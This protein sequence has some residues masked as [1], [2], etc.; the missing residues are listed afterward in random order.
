M[1]AKPSASV[2][3]PVEMERPV[4][5]HFIINTPTEILNALSGHTT[6]RIKRGSNRRERHSMSAFWGKADIARRH[7]RDVN[8]ST[9]PL[10]ASKNKSCNAYGTRLGAISMK[11]RFPLH[12]R[13]LLAALCLLGLKMEARHE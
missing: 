7:N 9:T 2:S 10:T 1:A 12:C 4:T 5:G 8:S 13:G 6:P 3:T 11:V